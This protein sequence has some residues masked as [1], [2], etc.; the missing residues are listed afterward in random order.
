MV[1]QHIMASRATL[2]ILAALVGSCTQFVGKV[3]TVIIL[4]FMCLLLKCVYFVL[5]LYSYVQEVLLMYYTVYLC[6]LYL[7]IH[8][9]VNTI[10]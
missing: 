6:G 10:L 1:S 5:P 3:Q 4:N 9:M 7:M 2:L 8:R